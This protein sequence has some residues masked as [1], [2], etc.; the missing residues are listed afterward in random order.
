[1]MVKSMM[2]QRP[3]KERIGQEWDKI[4]KIPQKVGKNPF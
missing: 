1:M 4:G 2:N 3:S